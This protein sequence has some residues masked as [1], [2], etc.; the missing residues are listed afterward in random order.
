MAMHMTGSDLCKNI[1]K[2]KIHCWRLGVHIDC[3]LDDSRLE[4]NGGELGWPATRLRCLVARQPW[5]PG[6]LAATQFMKMYS[7]ALCPRHCVYSLPFLFRKSGFRHPFP[8][9]SCRFSVQLLRYLFCGILQYCSLSLHLT[10]SR[11]VTASVL[12][13]CL[14]CD[15]LWSDSAARWVSRKSCRPPCLRENLGDS[16]KWFESERRSCWCCTLVVDY[17]ISFYFVSFLRAWKESGWNQPQEEHREHW[18]SGWSLR[19]CCR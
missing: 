16:P 4:C 12:A 9:G 15:Y 3:H 6:T 14:A 11:I 5:Q 1:N 17:F 8:F 18:Q 10:L 13:P 2:G 7:W 19:S